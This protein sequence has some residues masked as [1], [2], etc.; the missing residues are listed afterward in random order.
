MVSTH[1]E[2]WLVFFSL[3]FLI[4]QNMFRVSSLA[5]KSNTA[6]KRRDH[7]YKDQT[8]VQNYIKKMPPPCSSYGI[9]S[10][11]KMGKRPTHRSI[12]NSAN[13]TDEIVSDVS[14]FD[15]LPL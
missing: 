13:G 9:F 2:S 11:P 15:E 1:I 6:D 3:L 7:F 12:A 8:A 10:S 5:A 4:L 14:L